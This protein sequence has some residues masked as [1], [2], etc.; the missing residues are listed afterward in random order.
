MAQLPKE[1]TISIDDL[2]DDIDFVIVDAINDY[3]KSKF[4]RDT[5]TYDY[6]VKIKVKDIYW[7]ER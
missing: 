2:F 6:D 4:G 5:I 1:L 3:L 7:D